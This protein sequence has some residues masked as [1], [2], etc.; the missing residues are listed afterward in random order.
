[1]AADGETISREGKGKAVL[2]WHTWK[3][4]LFDQGRK[5]EPP[6]VVAEEHP[7]QVKEETPA[8]ELPSL[9]PQGIYAAFHSITDRHPAEVSTILRT[10]LLQAIKLVPS[11]F[12]ISAT[13][14]YTSYILPSRPA[15]PPTAHTL[16]DIKHSTHKSLTAF[17]KL[18]EKDGL[19]KLKD[20]KSELV[21]TAVFPDHA[22]VASHQSYTTLKDA[23]AKRE[24]REEAEKN[25]IRGLVIVEKWKPHQQTIPFFQ[26]AGRECVFSYEHGY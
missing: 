14:F 18:C 26:Q 22:D 13:T 10:S 15:H 20:M 3:D 11:S 8:E 6:E 16:V 12:P 1:M 19:I 23:E 21:I 25:R 5:G 17:L 24:E 7:V 2:V 4:A 9:T